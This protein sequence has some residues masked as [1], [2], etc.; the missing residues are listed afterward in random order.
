[1]ASWQAYLTVAF[2]K[3]RVKRNLKSQT[4]VEQARATLNAIKHKVPSGITAKQETIGG[5]PGEWLSPDAGGAAG[6]LLYLHG[7]AYFACSSQT[8]RPITGG[9]ARRGLEVFA[10]DYRL[11]PENPFPAAVDDA[12]AA[13]RGLLARGVQ[14]SSLVVGGDSAGGGLAL[15]M[16]LSL[17]DAGDP[18][19]AAAVL[20]SPWTDL[21][22]TGA[23]L[24]SNSRRDAMFTGEGFSRASEPYLAGADP[25]NPLASPLYADLGGFPPMLIHVGSY[26]V[27]LDDSLRVAERARAAGTDVTLQ[28]WPVVPHVWQLF[29][30]PEVKQSMDAAATFLR[31]ALQARSQRLAA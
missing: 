19:P 30:M 25:R 4:N 3:L 5:V 22:G 8:H 31:N 1:M 23:T 26:E 6:T 21:A 13:Y 20:F 12:I 14:P 9:F 28:T 18:M 29:R 10:A 16:L 2:L 7:G 24:R 17:R 15:A 27:L 11:A